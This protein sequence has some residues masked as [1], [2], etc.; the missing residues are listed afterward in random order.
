MDFMNTA[1]KQIWMVSKS[2]DSWFI[3]IVYNDNN[4]N[5][6]SVFTWL[7]IKMKRQI[8]DDPMYNEDIEEK[9]WMKLRIVEVGWM[10]KI[11]K[12]WLLFWRDVV[13]HNNWKY[14]FVEY[15]YWAKGRAE[16][17]IKIWKEA[18]LR[19]YQKPKVIEEIDV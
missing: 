2:L 10:Y 6:R 16:N 17:D 5:S 9:I 4:V 14:N 1:T 15:W 12:K 13:L 3:L 19:K 11:Q 8:Q 7:N 18:R